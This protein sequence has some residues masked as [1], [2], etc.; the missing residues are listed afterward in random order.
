MNKK[1]LAM[2][3]VL[4][5]LTATPCLAD[6]FSIYWDSGVPD[7]SH[8]HGP[9][10]KGRMAHA[11]RRPIPPPYELAR[12]RGGHWIHAHRGERLGWWWVVGDS[13]YMYPGPVY[14]YPDLYVRPVTILQEPPATAVILS[15][16]TVVQ[17]VPPGAEVKFE[18]API[19]AT[20]T[21]PTYVDAQGRSCRE[22]Q[23][24][25]NIS[26]TIQQVYGTAC[27]SPD[28]SWRVVR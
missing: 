22:Y 19:E 12:W 4:L 1:T 17:T 8:E 10:V 13:W 20:Q 9:R 15:P 11:P 26:G 28:G 6:S 7:R 18:A 2:V 25:A 23:T 16:T 5:S 21:S 24:T 27:A 14:P 3:A